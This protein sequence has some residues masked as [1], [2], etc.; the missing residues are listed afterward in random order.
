MPQD[1]NV[2]LSTL[3]YIHIF[4]QQ[5]HFDIKLYKSTDQRGVILLKGKNM[6]I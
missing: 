2:P 1:E 6:M 5:R 4:F 3:S